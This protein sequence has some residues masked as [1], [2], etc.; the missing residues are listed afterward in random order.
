MDTYVY[1]SKKQNNCVCTT[2]MIIALIELSW[3]NELQRRQWDLATI[4]QFYA[5][6]FILDPTFVF[7]FP[8]NSLRQL[9]FTS[10]LSVL[11]LSIFHIHILASVEVY[12]LQRGQVN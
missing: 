3:L 8:A 10:N 12:S 7:S 6:H 5:P 2:I 1:V 4:P 11:D 9:K